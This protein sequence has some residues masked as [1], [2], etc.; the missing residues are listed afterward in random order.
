MDFLNYGAPVLFF[1]GASKAFS[2]QFCES[3]RAASPLGEVLFRVFCFPR[4][5]SEVGAGVKAPQPTVAS[6][7]W[8][9]HTFA[10][11]KGLSMF[12]AARFRSRNDGERPLRKVLFFLVQAPGEWKDFEV[13]CAPVV[14]WLQARIRDEG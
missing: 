11:C 6:K 9:W 10:R 2:E 3:C 13:Q 7:A 4:P 1:E 14:D 12:K 8:L 5:P